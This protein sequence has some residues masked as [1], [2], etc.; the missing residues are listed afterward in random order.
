M[1]IMYKQSHQFLKKKKKVQKK[2]KKIH[3]TADLHVYI[4]KKKSNIYQVKKINSFKYF[5][6]C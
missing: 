5:F 4:L 3:L 2:E 6:C 1:K